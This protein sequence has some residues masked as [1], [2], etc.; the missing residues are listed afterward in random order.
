MILLY[1]TSPGSSHSIDFFARSYSGSIFSDGMSAN[2]DITYELYDQQT[3]IITS[4]SY[5]NS[6]YSE[7]VFAGDFSASLSDKN[8]YRIKSY[9]KNSNLINNS[10]IY[11]DAIFVSSS[12]EQPYTPID[13]SDFTVVN[14]TKE[15]FKIKSV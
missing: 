12:M 8:W 14:K 13:D 15:T 3:T 4:G 6:I 1:N 2:D 7:G 10:I 11:V 5:L 9:D